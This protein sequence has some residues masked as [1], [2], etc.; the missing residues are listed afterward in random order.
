M[1]RDVYKEIGQ[2]IPIQQG[3]IINGCLADRCD[4]GIAGIIITPRCDMEHVG[5]VPTIHYLPIISVDQWVNN[6]GL[7][8][9]LQ[10]EKHKLCNILNDKKISATILDV[11]KL[12]DTEK[13]P[14]LNQK[15]KQR[16]VKYIKARDSLEYG[17][18]IT[19]IISSEFSLLASNQHCRYYLLEDWNDPDCYRVVILREVKRLSFQLAMQYTAGFQSKILN[20][21]VRVLNDIVQP[22]ANI[23]LNYYTLAQLN[24]P[25]IEHLLQSFSHNF[26]RIGVEDLDKTSIINKYQPQIVNLKRL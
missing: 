9:A 12:E 19:S 11:L 14:K 4:D 15:E 20:N 5:K 18:S 23:N 10:Q 6:Y 22:S 16:I 8:A 3:V 7:P 17:D 24:S 26:C 25:F 1:V 21:D 13:V 2:H